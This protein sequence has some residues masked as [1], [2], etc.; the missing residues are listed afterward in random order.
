MLYNNNNDNNIERRV[1][2][3]ILTNNDTNI[4][5]PQRQQRLQESYKSSLSPSN[6]FLKN[7][8]R[9]SS[10]SNISLDKNNNDISYDLSPSSSSPMRRLPLSNQQL[11]NQPK[12]Q[13][14]SPQYSITF[15]PGPMGLELEPVIISSEREIGCRVKD[16]YFG[17]DHDGI[18]EDYVLKNIAVGDIISCISG[19]VVLSSKFSDILDILRSLKGTSRTIIF[20]NISASWNRSNERSE[21]DSLS[22]SRRVTKSI[23]SIDRNQKYTSTLQMKPTIASSPLMRSPLN[24]NLSYDKEADVTISFSREQPV[25]SSLLISPKAVK[26]M[27][28]AKLSSNKSA[29]Q[30]PVQRS[31]GRLPDEEATIPIISVDLNRVLGNIGASIGASILTIGNVLG[32]VI[33]ERAERMVVNTAEKM[34]RYNMNEMDQVVMKKQK[35]LHELSQ[36]CYLLGAA[37][38]SKKSLSTQ[39]EELKANELEISANLNSALEK[40]AHLENENLAL[41][42]EKTDI[43]SNLQS[44]ESELVSVNTELNIV[45]ESQSSMS[46]RII[47][48]TADA[49]MKQHDLT[50]LRETL[51]LKE[52]ELQQALSDLAAEVNLRSLDQKSFQID[53]ERALAEQKSIRSEL[54]STFERA[55]MQLEEVEN[56][57]DSALVELEVLRDSVQADRTAYEAEQQRARE[58]I[59]VQQELY[60]EQLLQKEE[61]IFLQK[62]EI[63]DLKASLSELKKF[64]A[65]AELYKVEMNN[66]INDAICDLAAKDEEL[67]EVKLRFEIESPKKVKM[68]EDMDTLRENLLSLADRSAQLENHV[69]LLEQKN[70]ILEGEI[71]GLNYII[72]ECKEENLKLMASVESSSLKSKILSEELLLSSEQVND[73]EENILLK[74]EEIKDM[75]KKKEELEQQLVVVTND[76]E[77]TTEQ[78]NEQLQI[79]TMFEDKLKDF[80][81]YISHLEGDRSNLRKAIEDGLHNYKQLEDEVEAY[82]NHMG[83]LERRLEERDFSITELNTKLDDACAQH[84]EF[85][86][87]LDLL[88]KEKND[89]DISLQSANK[90]KDLYKNDAVLTKEKLLAATSKNSQIEIEFLKA[91]AM[92]EETHDGIKKDLQMNIAQLQEDNDALRKLSDSNVAEVQRLTQLHSD[93]QTFAENELAK[94]SNDLL[95]AS[96]VMDEMKGNISKQEQVIKSEVEKNDTLS[97]SLAASV[98]Q[99]SIINEKLAI[100]MEAHKEA[101]FSK[102]Q[103]ESEIKELQAKVVGAN[104]EKIKFS[105]NCS[106]HC[107]LCFEWTGSL[108]TELSEARIDI[109]NLMDLNSQMSKVAIDSLSKSS[110]KFNELNKKVKSLEIQRDDA[111]LKLKMAEQ[112]ANEALERYNLSISK[113]MDI[114][115]SKDGA[116]DEVASLHK[117]L[118]DS[119]QLYLK[120]QEKLQLSEET[121]LITIQDFNAETNNL[122]EHYE[123]IVQKL[124]DELVVNLSSF[125]ESLAEKDRMVED[126]KFT[127]KVEYEKLQNATSLD[128]ARLHEETVVLNKQLT[129]LSAKNQELVAQVTEAS[130]VINEQLDL[131]KVAEEAYNSKQREVQV[132]QQVMDSSTNSQLVVADLERALLAA[133]EKLANSNKIIHQINEKHDRL[134]LE[135]E[136]SQHIESIL[137]TKITDQEA[138]I[139]NMKTDNESQVK[140]IL[141]Q[142]ELLRVNVKEIEVLKKAM[143]ESLISKY[144]NDNNASHDISILK[145]QLIESQQNNSYLKNQL[146]DILV[147]LDAQ[148][149]ALKEAEIREYEHNSTIKY[150]ERL[151]LEAGIIAKRNSDAFIDIADK[152]N[153]ENIMSLKAANESLSELQQKYDQKCVDHDALSSQVIELLKSSY[154]PMKPLNTQ[155][156]QVNDVPA[157]SFNKFIDYKKIQNAKVV[158]TPLGEIS[159][160]NE[161][162]NNNDYE[163]IYEDDKNDEI[164]TLVLELHDLIGSAVMYLAKVPQDNFDLKSKI[165]SMWYEIGDKVQ[166]MYQA[167]LCSNDTILPTIPSLKLMVSSMLGNESSFDDSNIDD[168]LEGA[169]TC[170][171]NLAPIKEVDAS[172]CMCPVGKQLDNQDDASF[173]PINDGLYNEN[174]MLIQSQQSLHSI[175]SCASVDGNIYNRHNNIEDDDAVRL[176]NNFF[177]EISKDNIDNESQHEGDCNESFWN[178]STET[179]QSSFCDL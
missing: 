119:V 68:T 82:K 20:K 107:D 43:L 25:N 41:K 161:V 65:D 109:A 153:K 121:S 45:T 74:S 14:L 42:S 132:A 72:T 63:S 137:R 156:T 70:G 56:A 53:M 142:G 69:H 131:L 141:E 144:A 135:L 97:K 178:V 2:G 15:P 157:I 155:K 37:E 95:S 84:Q 91:V 52:E 120:T 102:D 134:V 149:L 116:I 93:T 173:H 168:S 162:D 115:K 143:Q 114:E 96:S 18:N 61:D 90:E 130:S 139:V 86:R 147:A 174:N 49:N 32:N 31:R 164:I 80:Q 55:N 47:D 171:E 124:Q 7:N 44:V 16:F 117:Q 35:L 169:F 165:L 81:E 98:E 170:N 105:N 177:I 36:S 158:R 163:I 133:E 26:E 159:N 172:R 77:S 128:V 176:S 71:D 175:I 1:F 5:S 59:K 111:L 38:E 9:I 146:E 33:G 57:R 19:Q 34:P 30:S 39:V 21:R 122:K 78:W 46:L 125:N 24:L 118:N 127:S 151:V 94:A 40:I 10:L 3:K 28:K 152:E 13:H 85:L 167:A 145:E 166:Q 75:T 112:N 51:N 160:N 66:K 8:V 67:R 140:D 113:I 64:K 123:S 76:L 148:A 58:N 62:K 54:E 60:K 104:I 110:I 29:T 103:L 22:P 100:A 87:Q 12:Q 89:L 23:V 179:E 17:V 92:S 6:D 101:A 27:S 129:D 154:T 106:S 136:Q 79:S 108:R 88:I 48:L 11:L 150:L 126:L 83:V 4:R 99:L 50:D 73:L 138:A